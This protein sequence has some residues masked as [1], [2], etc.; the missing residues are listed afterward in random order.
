MLTVSKRTKKFPVLKINIACSF[1]FL[2][3]SSNELLR[4]IIQ[5]KNMKKKKENGKNL[6][7]KS[8]KKGF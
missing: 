3:L 6:L 7:D 5:K 2:N 4:K 8:L 1:N